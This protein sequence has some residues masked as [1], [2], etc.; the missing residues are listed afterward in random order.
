MPRIGYESDLCTR[1]RNSKVVVRCGKNFVLNDAYA[2]DSDDESV[3][4]HVLIN[5][6]HRYVAS[7]LNSHPTLSKAVSSRYAAYAKLGMIWIQKTGS[8]GMMQE[9]S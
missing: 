7:W 2:Y 5:E 4:S 9:A 3:S 6:C 1:T 8:S